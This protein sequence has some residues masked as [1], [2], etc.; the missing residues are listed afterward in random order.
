MGAR[1]GARNLNHGNQQPSLELQSKLSNNFK[2][3]HQD[4]GNI[5]DEPTIPSEAWK[6]YG[7]DEEDDEAP[8]VKGESSHPKGPKFTS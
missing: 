3:Y 5:Y 8:S 1:G 2:K 6:N 4:E 7:R